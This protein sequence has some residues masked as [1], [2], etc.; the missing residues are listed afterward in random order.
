MDLC[1]RVFDRLDG[2]RRHVVGINGL[3]CSGKTTFATSLNAFLAAKGI[4]SVV[5]N[6]D[7]FNDL[8]F[9]ERFYQRYVSD[10]L[11]RV[12]L[13]DY[14]NSSINYQGLLSA[15][16]ARASGANQSREPGVTIVEGVFLFKPIFSELFNTKVFLDVSY[17][18]AIARYEQRRIQVGD[19]RPLSVMTDIWIPA[20]ERYV[21][22][23]D[24]RGQSDFVH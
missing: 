18:D 21:D 7:D 15:I 22:R 8:T 17:A 3:D 2:Q 14:Y 4:S 5:L 6:V 16:T 10:G 19:K 12:D 13:E 23:C 20:F 1:E 24:P 11:P 9:Q